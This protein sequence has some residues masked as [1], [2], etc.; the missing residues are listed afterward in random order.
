MA[1]TTQTAQNQQ[2][3]VREKGFI[4]K[5]LSLP[6]AFAG[7][8]LSSLLVSISME[9]IGLYFYW[10][11]LGWRH[12]QTMLN[13][14]LQWISTGFVKS[15][16]MENPGKTAK[17]LIDL[18]Y[19]WV[20]EKSGLIEWINYSAVQSRLHSTS[21]DGISQFLG[22]V[23]VY[24]EDYGLAAVY[25]CLTF[26]TRMVILVL[27]TPLFLM[28]A[29]TGMVDGLVRRD[30]RRFGAGRESGFIYHRAKMMIVPLLVAPWVIY[31][32]LPVSLSPV[33]ILLPCAVALGLAVSI[34]AGSFKK[35]L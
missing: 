16:I 3:Q 14:E 29:F 33:L 32:A 9:W 11:E 34:T 27:T 30:L 10:P 7:V 31:L 23:Y 25:T 17:D 21:N 26:L 35:Y 13:N 1:T 12:A 15:L 6:F 20:F 4:G 19:L 22:R 28:A 18:S 8:L 24:V 2:Q 5:T